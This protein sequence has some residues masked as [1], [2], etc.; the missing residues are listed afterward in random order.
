[1]TLL[2]KKPRKRK[3]LSLFDLNNPHAIVEVRNSK[4]DKST[5]PSDTCIDYYFKRVWH[6]PPFTSMN[7]PSCGEKMF[8]KR[9]NQDIEDDRTMVGA[10]VELVMYPFMKYIL[11]LCKSCNDKKLALRPFW[12]SKSSLYPLSRRR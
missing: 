2:V 1:M 10:H 6:T 11:P 9:N 5:I 3:A 7:C 8:L 12:I 4:T